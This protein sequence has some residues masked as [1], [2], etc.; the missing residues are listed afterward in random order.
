VTPGNGHSIH[1][2]SDKWNDS[3]LLRKLSQLFSFAKNKKITIQHAVQQ[4]QE[5]RYKMFHTP[6]STVADEQCTRLQN[7]LN[8]IVILMENSPMENDKWSLHGNSVK[9]STKKVYLAITKKGIAPTPF[10]W[11]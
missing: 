5:D 7:T 2:W 8:S 6:L 11:I 10:M 3:I 1:L 4:M 9:Y